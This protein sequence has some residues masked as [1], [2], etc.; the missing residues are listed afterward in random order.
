MIDL[1]EMD[2]GDYELIVVST[3]AALLEIDGSQIRY[4]MLSTTQLGI[5]C[6]LLCVTLK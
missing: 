5:M 3:T 6:M 4:N 2:C 1:T